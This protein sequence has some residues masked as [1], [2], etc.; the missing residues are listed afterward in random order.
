MYRNIDNIIDR[1][2][3]DSS[4]YLKFILST[5]ILLTM[6]VKYKALK[7]VGFPLYSYFEVYFLIFLESN[8]MK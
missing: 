1:I 3:R 2:I 6:K 8:K 4:Q 7:V 5:L